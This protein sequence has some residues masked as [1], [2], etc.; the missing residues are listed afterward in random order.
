M[1]LE[2]QA[3]VSE[4]TKAVAA[5]GGW[6]VFNELQQP[7]ATDTAASATAGSGAEKSNLTGDVLESLGEAGKG[8]A[9]VTGGTAE[10]ATSAPGAAGGL[11]Q[12]RTWVSIT[13]W[14]DEEQHVESAKEITGGQLEAPREKVEAT[15]NI[16][17]TVHLKK[18][19]G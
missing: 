4:K 5:V 10:P 16:Y 7:S 2:A 9:P 1:A 14:Q 6:D 15:K 17:E 8:A 18:L 11:P 13:G 3:H 12:Y 19:L